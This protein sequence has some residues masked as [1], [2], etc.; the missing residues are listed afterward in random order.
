MKTEG[1]VVDDAEYKENE[2]RYAEVNKRLQIFG[3]QKQEFRH[4]HLRENR[5]I[6]HKRGHSLCCRLV[7]VCKNKV[8]AE[9]IGGKMRDVPVSEELSEN[10]PHNEKHKKR[11]KYAPAHT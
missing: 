6:A 10:Q 5:R 3:K 2:K 4:V 11:R 9:K 8:S 1:D 7:K